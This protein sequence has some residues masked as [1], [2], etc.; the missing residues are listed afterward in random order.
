[1]I[2]GFLMSEFQKSLP[3]MFCEYQSNTMIQMKLNQVVYKY[4]KIEDSLKSFV[5][6]KVRTKLRTFQR[7]GILL[8][9]RIVVSR[10]QE[11]AMNLR[12]FF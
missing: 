6:E 1:M 10:F 4:I 11:R 12:F 5:K 9:K 8:R 2:L 3:L 7:N